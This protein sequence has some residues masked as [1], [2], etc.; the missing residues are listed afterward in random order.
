MLVNQIAVLA[1]QSAEVIELLGNQHRPLKFTIHWP[2]LKQRGL[3]LF[4]AAPIVIN[5][6]EG[7]SSNP[8]APTQTGHFDALLD[9]ADTSETKW[10]IVNNSL[11][12]QLVQQGA[13]WGKGPHTPG[14]PPVFVSK[15]VAPKQL[16]NTCAAAAATNKSSDVFKL[17]GRRNELHCRLSRVS[18]TPQ[19]ACVTRIVLIGVLLHK[20]LQS[21]GNILLVPHSLMR[22][23]IVS[24]LK[25]LHISP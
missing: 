2:T 17:V 23:G 15:R 22:F 20:M 14:K 8:P 3:V 7:C 6:A 10:E 12:H 21:F 9:A 18:N 11:I 24:G 4:K 16:R 5:D 19:D 25:L 13:T 1:L